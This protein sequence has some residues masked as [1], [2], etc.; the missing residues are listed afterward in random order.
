MRTT[1]LAL[2][3]F[4]ATLAMSAS[5]GPR[6][7]SGPSP[8]TYEALGATPSLTILDRAAPKAAAAAK[9]APAANAAARP[10]ERAATATSGM[11]T[12]DSVGATPRVGAAKPA[13]TEVRQPAR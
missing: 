3:A 6:M 8:F 5:A 2:A 1:N 9:Q 10:A 12:Y 13:I 11:F 4:F 7:E